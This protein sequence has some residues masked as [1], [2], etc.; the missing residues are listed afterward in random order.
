MGYQIEVDHDRKFIRYTHP[1]TLN[2]ADIGLAWQELLTIKEFTH[3]HYNLFSDYRN[4]KFDMPLNAI[5]DIISFF[6]D[7]KKIL[8]GKRQ[9]ILVDS[10]IATFALLLFEEKVFANI[11]FLVKTFTTEKAAVNWIKQ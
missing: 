9:A 7:I 8:Y 1:G 4:A 11:G 5:N 2:F 6:K 10:S 3:S